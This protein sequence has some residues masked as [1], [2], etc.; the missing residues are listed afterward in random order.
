LPF[1]QRF[2]LAQNEYGVERVAKCS[3]ARND[4]SCV[5]DGSGRNCV[6]DASRDERVEVTE[7][8]PSEMSEAAVS[9]PP[10]G[11]GGINHGS[12]TPASDTNAFR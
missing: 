3:P 1:L 11:P 6:T 8:G 5:P 7:G 12:I 10:V 2:G 9:L 4:T